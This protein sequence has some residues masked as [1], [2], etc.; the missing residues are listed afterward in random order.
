MDFLNFQDYC[1]SQLNNRSLVVDEGAGYT[2]G[3]PVKCPDSLVREP[4]HFKVK[5]GSRSNSEDLYFRSFGTDY[6][7]SY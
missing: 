6:R 7:D 1:V 5:T 2:L 4:K 3:C